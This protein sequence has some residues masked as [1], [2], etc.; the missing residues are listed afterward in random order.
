MDQSS[1][2]AVVEWIAD[3]DEASRRAQR[4]SSLGAATNSVLHDLKNAMTVLQAGALLLA[5][6]KLGEADRGVVLTD[7]RT[8]ADEASQIVRGLSRIAR[9]AELEGLV[10][11]PAVLDHVAQGLRLMTGDEVVVD[12]M[13]GLGLARVPEGVLERVLT[14]V[15]LEVDEALD[16]DRFHLRALPVQGGQTLCIEL[17]VEGDPGARPALESPLRQVRQRLEAV[18]GALRVEH[19]PGAGPCITLEVPGWWVAARAGD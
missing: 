3:G 4:R 18:G 17:R 9:T 1:R 2:A 5:D 12:V 15:I 11:V 14:G 13:P 8:A 6:E 10:D 19:E 7:L 16:V